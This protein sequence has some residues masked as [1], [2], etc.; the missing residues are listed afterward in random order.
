MTCPHCNSSETRKRAGATSVG[1][2]RFVCCA[3]GRRFNERTGTPFNELQYP[4]DVVLNAVLWRLRYKL[5]LRDVAELLLLRGFAVTHETVREWE[6]R[7]ASI[8][9]DR[10]REKRRGRR[11]VSWYLDETYVKVAGHWRYLYRAIDRDGNLLDSMLSEHRD[12]DA[13]RRFLRQL[14]DLNGRRP[15]RVTTDRHPAYQK[16]IRWIVGKKV[17]HRRQQYLNNRTEQDHRGIKQRYYP[18]LGFGSFASASRFCLAFD[19]LR[20]Y[21]R[22]RK[23]CGEKVS[24]GAQ[25]E[26]FAERWRVLVAEM[27]AA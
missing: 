9:A 5:S 13:A 12:R 21:F 10:L 22:R 1:Y 20:Q 14:L 27:A 8:L 3:C 17:T 15:L 16:A 23:H 24:L 11:S 26:Q 7:F 25:R 2:A 6:A 4:T 19:A 18:M